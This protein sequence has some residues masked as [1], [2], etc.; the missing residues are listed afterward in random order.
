MSSLADG[1]TTF[2]DTRQRLIYFN[3]REQ[4]GYIIPDEQQGKIIFYKSRFAAVLVLA[5]IM[6]SFFDVVYMPYLMGII[7]LLGIEVYFRYIFLKK[8]KTDNNFKPPLTK[9]AIELM[10][11]HS[12]PSKIIIK[13][14]LYFIFAI[15]IL[16]NSYQTNNQ[17]L[18]IF[19]LALSLGGAYFGCLNIYALI[20]SK[21]KND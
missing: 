15:L 12:T 21:K 7:A 1:K 20:K 17:T 10:V 6:T 13:S 19:S 9:P 16:V 2:I 3:K 8:M 5:I 14:I 4:K 11:E 18:D